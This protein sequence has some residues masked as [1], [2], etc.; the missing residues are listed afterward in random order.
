MVVASPSPSSSE[1]SPSSDLPTTPR[2]EPR[3][4]PQPWRR[5]WRR[6][7]A[8]FRPG[9]AERYVHPKAVGLVNAEADHNANVDVAEDSAPNYL[10]WIA[11]RCRPHLGQRVLEV[12]AGTGSI[13]ARFT[14]GR[15]VLATERSDWCIEELERRFASTPNVTVRQAELAELANENQRFDSIVMINVLE[16]I[17]DDVAALDEL[18]QLL[19][20]GGRIVLYVPALNGLYGAFDRK[21]GHY[22]RYAPWRMRRVFASAGLVEVEMRYMNLLSMP[23]WWIFSHGNVERSTAGRLSLWD[24]TGITVGRRLESIVRVPVGLN[25]FCVARAA[26]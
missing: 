18:R 24:R 26:D 13:T 8:A 6:L 14:D 12:G 22:R 3:P 16:H 11:D 17:E 21:A 2:P 20:P 25:L 10:T 1:T 15:E 5:P 19:T 7:G 23:A 4:E 9:P